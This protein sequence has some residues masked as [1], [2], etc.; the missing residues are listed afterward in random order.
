MIIMFNKCLLLAMVTENDAAAAVSCQF[1]ARTPSRPHTG[2]RPVLTHSGRRRAPASAKAARRASAGAPGRAGRRRAGPN[3]CGTAL[4]GCPPRRA[5][6]SGEC[7]SKRTSAASRA[8]APA[9]GPTAATAVTPGRPR[10]PGRDGAVP[11]LPGGPPLFRRAAPLGA[12]AGAAASTAGLPRGLQRTVTLAASAAR[13]R[14]LGLV[15]RLFV[16]ARS[17]PPHPPPSERAVTGKR[18]AL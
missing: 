14:P 13:N 10:A 3:R 16:G 18:R 1:L 7:G 8:V 2:V 15:K 11:G 12:A 4:A 17:R 6:G 5:A 9:A